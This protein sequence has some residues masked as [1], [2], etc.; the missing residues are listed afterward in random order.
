MLF[1]AMNL[2]P[3]TT[4]IREL[5]RYAVIALIVPGGCLI[6]LA[7]WAFRHRAW[8]ARRVRQWRAR[9]EPSEP[10]LL[11]NRMTVMCAAA[12]SRFDPEVPATAPN[13]MVFLRAEAPLERRRQERRRGAGVCA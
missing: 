8:L 4:P 1:R 12:H 5:G 7:I 6:A 2:P 11:L 3:L 10:G 9:A 13:A